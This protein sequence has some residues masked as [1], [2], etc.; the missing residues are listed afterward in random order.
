M[1]AEEQAKQVFQDISFDSPSREIIVSRV[2]RAIRAA[3][4]DERNA[5]MRIAALHATVPANGTDDHT[6]GHGARTVHRIV[7][8]MNDRESL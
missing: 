6:A 2:A 1:T 8:A 3:V 7:K 4:A 5:C